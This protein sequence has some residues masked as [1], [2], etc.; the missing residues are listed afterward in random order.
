MLRTG[1]GAT[2]LSAE[3]FSLH[4]A[5]LASRAKADMMTL[6]AEISLVVRP[7]QKD[8]KVGMPGI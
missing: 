1:K 3:R 5:S 7:S 6:A 2:R 4:L 8:R